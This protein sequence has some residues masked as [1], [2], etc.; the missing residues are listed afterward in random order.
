MAADEIRSRKARVAAEAALVRVVYH[1]G[2]RP[3][4]VLLGGLV[5]ELLCTGSRFIHAGTTDVDVQVNLE[6]ACE[7]PGASKLEKALR[8]ARFEPDE[9]NVWR[10]VETGS[11]TLVKFELLAD[12]DDQ[13]ASSTVRFQDCENL[14]AANLRGTGFAS[15][16]VTV[17]QLKA[18]VDGVP[19]TVE[20]NVTG[21]AGFLLAKVA[22]A[23]SRQKP[24]DWYDI[25]FVLLQN[26]AGGPVAAAQAVTALFA[27]DLAPLE[28]KLREL[29]AN[30]ATTSSQGPRAYVDQ[31]VQDH[32]EVDAPGAAADAMLAVGEFL[33]ALSEP[34]LSRTQEQ[35]M[36]PK[37]D[38]DTTPTG[39]QPHLPASS[40]GV[41]RLKEITEPMLLCIPM[42]G[43][44]G[45]G[46][47]TALITALHYADATKDGV[48]LRYVKDPDS[49]AGLA[50]RDE[51][52]SLNLPSLAMT[53]REQ[54]GQLEVEFIDS[55]KWP[56]GNDRGSHYLLELDN[57]I[58]APVFCLFPDLTGG[59]Y[60][61]NDDESR[62]A[63]ASSHAWG[64]LVSAPRYM[65]T[66]TKSKNYRDDVRAV[67]Q[68]A[69]RSQKPFCVMITKADQ[70]VGGASLVDGA[71][72]ELSAF[73]NQI[74][75]KVPNEVMRVSVTGI[76]VKDGDLPPPAIDRKP[77][78]VVRAYTWLI[79]Q[80]L[81]EPAKSRPA[82]SIA[83]KSAPRAT[84][85]RVSATPE[86]RRAAEQSGA[87]GH[88]VCDC[89][90][91]PQRR[92][93]A[94]VLDDGSVTEVSVPMRTDAEPAENSLG[95]MTDFD[96]PPGELQG[97]YVGGELLLAARQQPK[98]L[99][100]GRKGELRR[101]SFALDVFAWS[102][103]T[104][105]RLIALDNAG[106]IHSLR[107]TNDRWQATDTVD[108][109]SATEVV[110]GS[111]Q[112]V[113]G[114]TAYVGIGD[115]VTS[116]IIESDDRLGARG[117]TVPFP[118]A[119]SFVGNRHG[120]LYSIITRE[121]KE[122]LGVFDGS[123][124]HELG[125]VT[126]DTAAVAQEASII[127]WLDAEQKLTAAVI[128]EDGTVQRTEHVTSHSEGVHG[129]C[130]TGA[131]EALVAVFDEGTWEVY[132]PKGLNP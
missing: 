23:Y 77:T 69:V 65:G 9:Q 38:P 89:S 55:A 87:P 15:R 91:D 111:C 60:E 104:P 2:S 28:T 123:A 131:G 35:V 4:F 94:F 97:E 33:R 62:T 68:K 124:Y 118:G 7:S 20:L 113:A 63:L 107:L 83:V 108:D 47:T 11:G 98:F 73:I 8:D 81:R 19:I 26:D 48:G 16:D 67:I 1:Y 116:I 66:G 74:G 46:K 6:L 112:V 110:G 84:L 43:H 109:L 31:M 128:G 129:V 76:P 51:Y 85:S 32:P 132:I 126:S 53:T 14:G 52:H 125:P 90:D 18:L 88:P 42:W 82:I 86:L 103:V 92:L 29:K 79:N 80:A 70:R 17:R 96:V 119:A 5:P 41:D 3:E 93:L 36:P 102:P 64:I 12:L 59:S 10:W 114:R 101:T 39:S 95:K 44:L 49:L 106:R 25:A 72:T 22:A 120:L 34:S 100:I 21:L 78:E 54:L 57:A 99:W 122:I 24:K 71:Y 115:S 37:M 13:P 75:T 117:A 105:R 58:G 127:A 45:D 30:F 40:E 56:R 27:K 121:K 61:K 50:A 130:W